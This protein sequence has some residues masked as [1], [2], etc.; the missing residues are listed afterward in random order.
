MCRYLKKVSGVGSSEYIYFWKSKD[1]SDERIN[2]TTP[3]LAYLGSKV[4]VKCNETCLKQDKI[5]YNYR[6]PVNVNIVCEISK[7]VNINSYTKLE[8]CLFGE[9]SLTENN[10]IDRHEYSGHG[11]RFNRKREV[12]RGIGFVRNIIIFGVEMGS[13]VHADNKKKH[14]LT[15]GEGPPQGLDRATLITKNRCS[16]NFTENNFV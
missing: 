5:T 1:F 16:I 4:T 10:D 13:S 7:N 12:L 3:E 8:N 2:S 11:I 14:I 9:I 6:K 15:L